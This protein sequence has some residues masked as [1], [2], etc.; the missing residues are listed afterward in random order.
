MPLARPILITLAIL[1]FLGIYND[2]IWPWFM[3]SSPE[4][5]PLTVVLAAFNPANQRLP[6]RPELGI[7]TAAYVFASI[8]VLAVF[9]F[10]MRYY[11]E[12]LTSGAIKS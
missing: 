8:P 2:F 11:I 9:T 7:I 5:Q 6:G 1:N 3:I 12:G 10:G 4:L